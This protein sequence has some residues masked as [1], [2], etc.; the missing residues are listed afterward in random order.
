VDPAIRD[1]VREMNLVALRNQA[2]GL[3]EVVQ[4]ETSAAQRLGEIRAPA[5]VIVGEMDRPEIIAAAV[6]ASERIPNA[7]KVEIPGTAH[8]PNL[9]RPALFNRILLDFLDEGP[10]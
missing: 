6:L 8:L 7:R 4:S 2:T 1:L 9:E 3:G 10:D 5:L